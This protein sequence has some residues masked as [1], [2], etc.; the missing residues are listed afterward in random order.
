LTARPPDLELP[1][2]LSPIW[3]SV[4]LLVLMS[5]WWTILAR[6]EAERE[7]AQPT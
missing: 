5:P 4:A 2:R 7:R 1:R 6:Q 3:I